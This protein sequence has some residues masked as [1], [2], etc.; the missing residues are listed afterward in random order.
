VYG[1]IDPVSTAAAGSRIFGRT[2]VIKKKFPKLGGHEI[3][4]SVSQS[5]IFG[6]RF[7]L[8]GNGRRTENGDREDAKDRLIA[9]L[10]Q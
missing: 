5:V 2:N 1:A 9:M 6:N 10:D 4:E 3:V 8:Q 7:L